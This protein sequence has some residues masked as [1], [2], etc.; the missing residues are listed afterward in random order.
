MKSTTKI[1]N[2]IVLLFITTLICTTHTAEKPTAAATG[3]LAYA[4]GTLLNGYT[5]FRKFL[6]Y[7]A[8]PTVSTTSN[9]NFSDLP[10]EIQTT[11]IQLFAKSCADTSVKDAAQTINALAQTNKVL[12]TLINDPQFCLTLIKSR[13]KQF[14]CADTKVAKALQTKESKHRLVLQL[15]FAKVI[16]NLIEE[17]ENNGVLGQLNTLMAKNVDVDFTYVWNKDAQEYLSPLMYAVQHENKFLINYLLKNGA[18]I[19]RAGF[20]GKTPLMYAEDP[21]TLKF[22]ASKPNININQ[23]DNSGNT[24]LLRAIQ[25]YFPEDEHRADNLVVIQQLLDAGANP[26][27]TNNNGNAPLQEA[28]AT[29]DQDLVNLIQSAI[30]GEELQ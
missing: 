3:W 22:L 15:T 20:N 4:E 6:T 21:A 11:I 28:H 19:N 5:G 24:A 12:N 17:Q 8:I 23:Q 29:G 7:I 1:S 18:N 10:I 30:D 25:N 26:K 16:K 14:N 13:A 9:T 2:F 27:I